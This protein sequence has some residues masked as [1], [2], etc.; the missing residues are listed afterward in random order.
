MF[1]Q[2]KKVV[3]GIHVPVRSLLD[4]ASATAL[5]ERVYTRV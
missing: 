3:I 1:Q 4:P 2:E 5:P